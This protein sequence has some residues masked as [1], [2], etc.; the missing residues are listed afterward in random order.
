MQTKEKRFQPRYDA[1]PLKL[2]V[3]PIGWLGV[4]GKM[5]RAIARDFA[6]GGIAI[7][8]PIK[9]KLGKQVLLTLENKDHRLDSIPAQIVR[10]EQDRGDYVYALEFVLNDL[11]DSASYVTHN[12]LQKLEFSLGHL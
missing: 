1:S 10:I 7:I 2:E 6:L 3:R 9:M 12:V 5:H 8:S 11:S 4:T